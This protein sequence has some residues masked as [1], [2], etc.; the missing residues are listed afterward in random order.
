MAKAGTELSSAQ[1]MSCYL[2]HLE[3]KLLDPIQVLWMF[4]TQLNLNGD[5]DL[6]KMDFLTKKSELALIFL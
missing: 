1:G 4:H 3:K 2:S 6:N 5:R